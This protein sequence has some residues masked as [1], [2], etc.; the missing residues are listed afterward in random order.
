LKLMVSATV[1]LMTIAL[2]SCHHDRKE[3]A[4]IGTELRAAMEE[5]LPNS[6]AIGVSA[7][8]VFPDGELWAGTTGISHEGAPLTTDMLFDI[9]SVA[10]NFQA[11]LT[12]KLV[13]EGVIALDDPL[14]KWTPPMPHVDGGITIRQLLNMTSGIH[15]FV[16]DPESPF[17]IGYVNIDFGH[18]WTWEEIQKT[19][20]REPSFEP[21]T[22][23]QYSSTNYIVLRRVI[24]QATGSKQAALLEDRVLK[25]NRLDHTSVDF[26]GHIAET[27]RI[28]HGW[29]DTNGDRTPED[30]SDNSLN[31]IIS[32]SPMLVYSTPTDMARW[33]DA[34]Y[35]RKTALK[36]ETL[37]EMLVF[38]GPVQGEPLM[39]GYGLGVAEIDLGSLM[40]RWNLVRFYGHLGS[41][42]GYSTFVGYFPDYGVSL[43]IMSNR[44]CD[45]AS[46]RAITIVGGA[47]IDVLLRRLGA[48]ESKQGDSISDLIEQLK[49]SPDD[50]HLMYK[51]A[52]QHQANKDD[53]E[54]SLVYE[55]ILKTDPEDTYGYRTEALFWKGVYDGLIGKKPENLIAF[56]AEHPDYKDIK[57]AYRW[58]AKTYVRRNEMDKAVEVYRDALQAIGKDAEFYNEYAWW[59]YENKVKSEYETALG[60]AKSAAELKP[61]AYYIRDTLAWLYFERGE[62]ERAVEAA[63]KALNLAPESQRVAMEESLAKI[64]KGKS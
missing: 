9:G 6:G 54:A 58:L 25:P 47:V 29:F 62:R 42:F 35:H 28:A 22:K 7:A 56:I 53:Y 40:P 12:L 11:A 57:D 23:S 13:E 33:M 36:E 19:F 41:A 48:K 51:I 8:V 34:L 44:G 59:V 10:K 52:K 61:D 17:R 5:A 24:E 3:S 1:V 18:L 43:A 55:E 26:S 2:S 15:D 49:R 4:P 39:K 21:G 14:D 63:T 45:A 30:I 32:L 27:M 16:G 50:V 37:K 38:A 60:Y 64:K 31:W 20:L 46:E